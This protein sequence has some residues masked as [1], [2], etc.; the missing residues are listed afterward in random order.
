MSELLKR[1]E[2]ERMQGNFALSNYPND[3]YWVNWDDIVEIVEDHDQPQLNENQQ[4]VLEWLKREHFDSYIKSVLSNLY[5]YVN[6]TAIGD[7]ENKEIQEMV[8][9]YEKLSQEEFAQVLQ[10]FSTWALEQEEE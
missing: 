2:M 7:L 3:E 9:T 6:M 10:V 4:I 8:N 1:L 5:F